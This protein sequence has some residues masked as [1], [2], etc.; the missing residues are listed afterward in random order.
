MC[1]SA[2]LSSV[3]LVHPVKAV[4]QNEMPF[5]KDTRV[6]P[7]DI[8]LDRGPVPHEKGE[9]WRPEP[10]F[11][12]NAVYYHILWPLFGFMAVFHTANVIASD[13]ASI[14]EIIS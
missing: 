2:R 6:V 10:P 7:N 13:Q 8:V 9:I 4:G 11:R 1:P 3:T 5:G 12:V 14:W